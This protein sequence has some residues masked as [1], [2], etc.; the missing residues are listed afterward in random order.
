MS[1]KVDLVTSVDSNVYNS[2]FVSLRRTMHNDFKSKGYFKYN[3]Y[4]FIRSSLAV[5]YDI[6]NFYI[7]NSLSKFIRKRTYEN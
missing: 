7:T 5:I 2:L 3:G 4:F 6:L 1:K